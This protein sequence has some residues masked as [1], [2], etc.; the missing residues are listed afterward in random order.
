MNR[1]EILLLTVVAALLTV[2]ASS[3]TL[4]QQ[5]LFEFLITVEAV[6]IAEL[7]LYEIL[8]ATEATKLTV[9]LH[10][11][12]EK[13]GFSV[14]SDNRT[15]KSAYPIFDEDRYLWEDDDGSLHQVKDLYVGA[16]PCYFYPFI[17]TPEPT[18]W[19]TNIVLTEVKKNREVY[20][21]NSEPNDIPIRIINEGIE[22]K[23]DYELMS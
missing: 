18:E 1:F 15:I 14:E 12:K 23:R 7:A 10:G 17:A 16:K 3:L 4:I 19:G 9:K 20:F 5:G 13:I 8:K 6:V 21:D 22:T 11:K 2:Y